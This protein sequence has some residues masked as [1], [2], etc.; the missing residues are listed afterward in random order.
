MVPLQEIF[1]LLIHLFKNN[2]HTSG[3]LRSHQHIHVSRGLVS[4]QVITP[5]PKIEGLM[6]GSK[7]YTFEGDTNGEQRAYVS[8]SSRC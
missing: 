8:P 7:K 3:P 4:R 2:P 1:V 6:E 5:P